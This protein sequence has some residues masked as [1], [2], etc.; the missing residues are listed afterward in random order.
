MPNLRLGCFLL[1]SILWESS[2]WGGGCERERQGGILKQK[3]KI[4]VVF[5]KVWLTQGP[6]STS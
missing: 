4:R 2:A 1:Q 3:V 6:T 5:L